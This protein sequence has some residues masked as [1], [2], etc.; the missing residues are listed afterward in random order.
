MRSA[1]VWLVLI[2]VATG[3]C[4]SSTTGTIQSQSTLSQIK[5]GV[6]T[7]SE[8]EALLGPPTNVMTTPDGKTVMLYIAGQYNTQNDFTWMVPVVGGFIP[9]HN[10]TTNRQQQVTITLDSNNIVENCHV[11]DNTTE[12][13]VD[14]SIFGG[15]GRT[16][17]TPTTSSSGE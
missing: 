15:T 8:V 14:S 2:A 3:G 9:Q 10:S 6:T 5:D 13:N 11:S 17:T 16:V 7:R 4:T 12:S 1:Y